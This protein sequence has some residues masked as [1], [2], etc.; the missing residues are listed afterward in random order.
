MVDKLGAKNSHK[1]VAMKKRENCPLDN[2]LW[3]NIIMNKER[4]L[5]VLTTN[6]QERRNL[7]WSFLLHVDRV[8][9]KCVPQ[10][11]LFDSCGF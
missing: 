8:L 3:T 4:F 6:I 10:S 1:E 5:L 2:D 11:F 7:S 9:V